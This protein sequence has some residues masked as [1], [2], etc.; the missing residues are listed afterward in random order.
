MSSNGG[1][2]SE[3]ST[4][5]ASANAVASVIVGGARVGTVPRIDEEHGHD[6]ADPA[7]PFPAGAQGKSAAVTR[8]SRMDSPRALRMKHRVRSV[9]SCT[10]YEY[11]ISLM[12][13]PFGRT[14]CLGKSYAPSTVCVIYTSQGLVSKALSGLVSLPLLMECADIAELREHINASFGY[15]SIA[16]R[17][18]GQKLK[19]TLRSDP[20]FLRDGDDAETRPK[21]SGST[22][23][24][25][26]NVAL[27]LSFQ[28]E[29]LDGR[30]TRQARV[31]S[32][33]LFCALLPF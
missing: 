7:Q 1:I 13:A 10:C 24:R 15:I 30:C 19:H 32:Y 17:I 22:S 25:L 28:C 31:N 5:T 14:S 8:V 9:Y 6:T 2:Y 12:W 20:L 16:A 23:G 29:V 26:L 33:Q 11:L 21:S 27:D 18:R 4:D 3:Q